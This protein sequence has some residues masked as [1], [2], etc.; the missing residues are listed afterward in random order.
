M[1]KFVHTYINHI[2]FL[3]KGLLKSFCGIQTGIKNHE[4]LI[5]LAS[6][7]AILIW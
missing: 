4:I 5:V 6:A 7:T 3:N 2:F 1:W